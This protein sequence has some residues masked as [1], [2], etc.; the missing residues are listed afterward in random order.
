MGIRTGAHSW[1]LGRQLTT[2]VLIGL[3]AIPLGA[4]AD[5]EFALSSSSVTVCTNTGVGFCMG[6]VG[7]QYTFQSYTVTC[8]SD[9]T[10]TMEPDTPYSSCILPYV[11]S[12]FCA[13]SPSGDSIENTACEAYGFETEYVSPCEDPCEEIEE[14]IEEVYASVGDI[15]DQLESVLD[16]AELEE[17]GSE[18]QQTLEE[19]YED[20]QDQME[21]QLQALAALNDENWA[22]C[23]D[24]V[25]MIDKGTNASNDHAARASEVFCDICDELEGDF[26]ALVD[27]MDDIASDAMALLVQAEAVS[28]ED[29][30]AKMQSEYEELIDQ[31]TAAVADMVALSEQAAAE[32]CPD[33]AP[34][35]IVDMVTDAVTDMDDIA[36]ALFAECG[37]E[38]E[39]EEEDEEEPAEELGCEE[40]EK[41]VVI[42]VGELDDSVDDLSSQSCDTDDWASADAAY[43]SAMTA[44]QSALAAF[45]A[46]DGGN[47]ANAFNVASYEAMIEASEC[48]HVGIVLGC[49]DPSIRPP[50]C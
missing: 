28:C 12:A 30:R 27:E 47:C 22:S 9:G 6:N 41:A 16:Q 35:S 32:G 21:T 39:E 45:G 15:N 38:E 34:G 13:A 1:T 46:A 20:L 36:E 25:D 50:E 44:A 42:A 19:E 17:C 2:A 43:D 48:E 49:L 14:D 7:C 3:L 10:E 26:D 18:A 31:I 11:G 8:W 37:E 4:A 23:Q 5:D 24:A 40:A 29:G 33:V